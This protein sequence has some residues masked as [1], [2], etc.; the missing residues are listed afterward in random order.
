MTRVRESLIAYPLDG[1]WLLSDGFQAADGQLTPDCSHIQLLQKSEHLEKKVLQLGCDPAFAIL[2]AHASR[3]AVDAKSS[4]PICIGS[5]CIGKTGDGLCAYCRDSSAQPIIGS[6]HRI[7]GAEK[8]GIQYRHIIDW[9]LTKPGAFENYRYRE[10]LFPTHRSRMAYDALKKNAKAISVLLN[11]AAKQGEAQ[12][13]DTIRALLERAA[14]PYAESLER[15]LI[16]EEKY[17]CGTVKLQLKVAKAGES[18]WNTE[19]KR[20]LTRIT[21]LPYYS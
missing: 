4:P 14:V 21:K 20:T 11:L 9:L 8:H 15:L 17:F 6:V 13:D 16:C 12:V 2:G 18:L 7:R 19:Y 1:N 5:S 10:E 3:W